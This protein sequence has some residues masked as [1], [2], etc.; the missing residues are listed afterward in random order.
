MYPGR[1]YWV[2][3]FGLWLVLTAA[4]VADIAWGPFVRGPLYWTALRGWFMFFTPLFIVVA[5]AIGLAV[6]ASRGLSRGGSEWRRFL[7]SVV[8]GLATAAAV[9]ELGAVMLLPA[10]ALAAWLVHRRGVR[11]SVYGVLGGLGSLLILSMVWE[12]ARMPDVCQAVPQQPNTFSCPN[13]AGFV[14]PFAL[15]LLLLLCG[16]VAEYRRRARY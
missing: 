1:R 15:G 2:Y 13:G 4:L 9:V 16:V 5:F 14:A 11:R 8:L 6:N 3:S 12:N 7:A 10:L